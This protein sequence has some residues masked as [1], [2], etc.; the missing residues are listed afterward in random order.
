MTLAPLLNA[1]LAIQIHAIAALSLIPLTAIQFWRRKG[2]INHRLLGWIWV[3]LMAITAISSFWIHGIR[4][5]GPF[6]P[7][8]ALSVFT[9]VSLYLGIRARRQNRITA[10][11]GFMIGIAAGWAGAGLF[12]LLPGRIMFQTVFGS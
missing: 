1:S 5:I 7:I 2:G 4:L 6:S 3:V 9:L 8:H 11:R 10:H 12:T